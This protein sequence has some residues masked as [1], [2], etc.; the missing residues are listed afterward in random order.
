MYWTEN[1]NGLYNKIYTRFSKIYSELVKI[2]KINKKK[3]KRS[4]DKIQC[5]LPHSYLHQI[6]QFKF[7]NIF[8]RNLLKTSLI[9]TIYK[10]CC[11]TDYNNYRPIA[12]PPTI[13]KV[14][15]EV[16]TRRITSFL[17]KYK[18]ISGIQFGIQ[19][20]KNINKLLGNFSNC[21]NSSLS[22]YMHCL[23]L[24]IDFSKEFYTLKH[25]RLIQMLERISIKGNT[26][27]WFQNYLVCRKY[28]VK[29]C[30]KRRKEVA[31]DC[32]VP[33]GSKLGPILFII[34]ANGMIRAL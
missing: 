12:I 7:G 25:N 29:I 3:K 28:R 27:N 10:S 11:K 30:S 4:K 5:M 23:V 14:L 26:L 9:R 24:L 22:K 18:I 31:I 17:S 32:G 16:V 15:E 1:A 19:K 20:G 6:Y 34:Y 21:I 13:V 8:I 2:F 33:Q